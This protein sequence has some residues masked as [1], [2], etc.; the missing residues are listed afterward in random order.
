MKEVVLFVRGQGSILVEDK[1]VGRVS[2]GHFVGEMS[3]LV[4]G[5]ASATVVTDGPCRC[6]A[7]EK[8]LL[9]RMVDNDPRLG[10]ALQSVFTANVVMKLADRNRSVVEGLRAAAGREV[11]S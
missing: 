11:P 8:P 9:R 6:L 7:W 10:A 1:L 3:F 5:N 2:D 4:E